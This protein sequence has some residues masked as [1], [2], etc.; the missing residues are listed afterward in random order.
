[1]GESRSNNY[2]GDIV[3]SAVAKIVC[4]QVN[5]P[6]VNELA[7]KIIP[8]INILKAEVVALQLAL[9]I[10]PSLELTVREL[11]EGYLLLEQKCDGCIVHQAK[12][13]AALKLL[14]Q[15]LVAHDFSKLPR[16]VSMPLNRVY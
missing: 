12:T 3:G 7:L 6:T 2:S 8:V 16:N 14:N 13:D 1:L 10:L 11:K 9:S 5:K 4:V 15:A